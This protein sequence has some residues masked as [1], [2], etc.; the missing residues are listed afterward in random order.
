MRGCGRPA[1]ACG[2]V[3]ALGQRD[4]R[5]LAGGASLGEELRVRLR[6]RG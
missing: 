3:M 5:G 4:L 1:A 6:G 2:A